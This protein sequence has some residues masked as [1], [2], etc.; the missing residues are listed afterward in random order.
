MIKKNAPVI[1]IF[2][3]GIGLYVNSL[4]GPFIY[5]DLELVRNNGKLQSFQAL[6]QSFK[7]DIN[8]STGRTGFFYRPFLQVTYALDSHFW[9]GR[10]YG[11]HATSIVLHALAALALASLI[12]ILFG[13]KLVAFLTALLWLV[14]PVHTEAV[15]YIS[16][17]ADPLAAL[18]LL[19]ALIFYVRGD[20]AHRLRN[21]SLLIIFYALALLSKE[22]SLIFLA[23]I[24]LVHLV[25]KKRIQW[26]ALIAVATLSLFYGFLRFSQLQTLLSNPLNPSTLAERLPGFFVAVAKY[27]KLLAWPTNLRM[28]YGL[29][30]FTF[31]DPRAIVGVG[32]LAALFASLYFLRKNRVWVFGIGWFLITLLPVSNLFPIN[33][34]MAEHWLYLPSMGLWLAF[35]GLFSRVLQSRK[36]L[37]AALALAALASMYSQATMAQNSY[38]SDAVLFYERTLKFEPN[39]ARMCNNLA[40]VYKDRGDFESAKTFYQK[41]ITIDPNIADVYFNL[42]TIY[43]Q[44]N[45]LGTAMDCYQKTVELNPNF[46]LAYNNMGALYQAHGQNELALLQY[47]K[48]LKLNPNYKRAAENLSNIKMRLGKSN[49]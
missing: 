44:E 30:I 49:G 8:L 13:D 41:A 7:Q 34:F 38:W 25:F 21:L 45:D 36:R 35:A 46:A 47:E 28:E 31:A 32:I 39:N 33:A 1:F 11:Y 29:K 14:H 42:G 4:C 12:F 9:K 17:R 10:V 37:V 6:S 43:A 15:S 27:F 23:L 5:D 22:H 40:G 3:M 16:G 20:Y 24:A 48:A 19:L 18:L 2:L 26:P